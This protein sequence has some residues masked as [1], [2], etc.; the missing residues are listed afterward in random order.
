MPKSGDYCPVPANQ[1]LP[2]VFRK[3]RDRIIDKPSQR[4]R[5]VEYETRH[6][7]PSS[8]RSLTVNF[9]RGLARCRIFSMSANI[10]ATFCW[11]RAGTMTAASFPRRVIPLCSPSLARST[12]AESFCFASDMKEAM[13]ILPEYAPITQALREP[14]L[15]VSLLIQVNAFD[16]PDLAGLLSQDNR[17]RPCA[18][19][20]EAD[21]FEQRAIRDPSCGKDELFA[22][23]EILG[24]VDA[25]LVFHSHARQ[26]L[27][28]LRLY[29]ETPEH[30]PVK[31]ANGRR[32]DHTFR[33]PRRTHHRNRRQPPFRAR[34]R[35]SQRINR[36]RRSDECARQ[37]REYRQSAFHGAV[38]PAR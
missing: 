5:G 22:G 13:T 12:S 26:S 18:F 24:L 19:P 16:E 38:D 8:I 28:L 21:A 9:P 3:L 6:R 7:R 20:E 29:H 17:G 2:H 4:H 36:R 32:G 1:P 31:A 35:Q 25:I 27:F 11:L 30:I 33:C 10:C 34:P 14:N 37:R 23:G 15:E